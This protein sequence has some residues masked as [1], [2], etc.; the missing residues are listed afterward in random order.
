[1]RPTQV[2]QSGTSHKSNRVKPGKEL[3]RLITAAVINREFCKLLLA[4]PAMAIESGYD[5]EPF[6]LAV[7]E[8]E[9]IFSITASSL[10]DFAEQLT[11][12][13][14][15]NGRVNGNGYGHNGHNHN[16]NVGYGH[17]GHEIGD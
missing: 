13:G 11:K 4:D 5:G 1:V 15:S 17:N 2:F 12:N 6:D 14:N 3:S 8:Q 9:L 16:G 7:E 10:A